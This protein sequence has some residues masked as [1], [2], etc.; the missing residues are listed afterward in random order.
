[1]YLL[2]NTGT[3]HQNRNDEAFDMSHLHTII[4]PH[5]FNF[6]VRFSC[7][8]ALMSKTKHRSRIQRWVLLVIY[9]YD[10]IFWLVLPFRVLAN[11]GLVKYCFM[12][13]FGARAHSAIR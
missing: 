3:K 2:Q 11:V 8:S 13:T 9:A 6:N 12:R 7:I 5:H 4:R 1:M 10:H